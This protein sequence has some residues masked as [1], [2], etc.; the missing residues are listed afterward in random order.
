V[1]KSFSGGFGF[2]LLKMSANWIEA[3]ILVETPRGLNSLATFFS[4]SFLLR[5]KI[6]ILSYSSLRREDRLVCIHP[7]SVSFWISDHW[8]D[9]LLMY[10]LGINQRHEIQILDST[11]IQ[12]PKYKK[13][14]SLVPLISTFTLSLAEKYFTFM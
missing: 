5:V 6:A 9:Y 10:I 11:A 13:A 8:E 3:K 7:E 14:S 1:K 12:M 4:Y 2:T